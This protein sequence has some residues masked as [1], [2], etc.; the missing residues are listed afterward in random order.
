MTKD[1]AIALAESG[2]WHEMSAR[3]IATFQLYEDM[4]CMPFTVFHEAI[5]KTLGRP[6]YTH[7]FAFPGLLKKELR[8]ERE[9]PTL[10]EIINLIPADKRVI[11]VAK[12]EA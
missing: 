2:F 3:D 1:E 12:E 6:V 10:E 7:E 11:I 9:A 4:L 5:E 8:G